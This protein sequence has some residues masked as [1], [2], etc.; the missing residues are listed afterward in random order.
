MAFQHPGGGEVVIQKLK[1]YLEKRGHEVKLFDKWNDKIKDFDIIHEFS[2]L[3][4]EVWKD[5]KDMEKPLVLTPTAWPRTD[6]KAVLK[7]KVKRTFRKHNLANFLNYPDII[8]PTTNLEKNRIKNLYG[9]DESR[10]NVLYN[11]I[12]DPDISGENHFVKESGHS[13]YLLYVGSIAENKNLMTAIKVAQ[14]LD[15]KLIIVGGVKPGHE[16]Y[17]EKCRKYESDKIIFLGQLE[18][19]S[20]KLIDIYRGAKCLLVLSD[21]ETCSLVAMEA[22]A[23][24]TPVIITKHGGTQEV[25]KTFVSYV[26]PYSEKEVSTAIEGL[27]PG[28]QLKAFIKENYLWESIAEKLEKVYKSLL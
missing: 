20:T 27:K 7:M 10:F 23:V 4:W 5:Y 14:S 17:F 2:L 8:L 6:F 24:G 28:D 11:G 21:F 15:Q 3:E 12:D 25:F 18:Q 1:Q 26:E 19:G 13:D 16:K 22:G 9:I